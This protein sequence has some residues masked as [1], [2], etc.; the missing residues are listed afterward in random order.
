MSDTLTTA[1]G[2][3]VHVTCLL[4]AAA[5]FAAHPDEVTGTL[6]VLFQPAE[7]LGAGARA[8]VDDGL[9]DVVG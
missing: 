9:F 7:E 3:D 4:G 2:H 1:S 6:I 5:H 8:M